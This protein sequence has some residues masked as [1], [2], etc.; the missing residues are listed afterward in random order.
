MGNCA[1]SSKRRQKDYKRTS[2][3]NA[4]VLDNKQLSPIPLTIHTNQRPYSLLTDS[5]QQTAVIT[6]SNSLIQFYYS[7]NFDTT[8]MSSSNSNLKP[9]IPV[10]KSRLPV[11]Q[12]QSNK[13][14]TS[15][16]TT[17]R[18][19]NCLERVNEMTQTSSEKKRKN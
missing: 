2:L 17:N 10:S 12:S 18:T 14:T 5:D 16:G 13:P 15:I 1:S 8:C 7:S 4:I 3:E 6:D 19:S 11:H 9:R